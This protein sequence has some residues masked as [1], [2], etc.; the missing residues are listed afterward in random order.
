MAKPNCSVH[1]FHQT[2]ITASEACTPAGNAEQSLKAVLKEQHALEHDPDWG[3]LGHIRSNSSLID[4]ALSVAQPCWDYAQAQ[5]PLPA[6]TSDYRQWPGMI[7][8]VS[9]GSTES[10]LGSN[11]STRA[12]IP[13][14]LPGMLTQEVARE[15]GQSYFHGA[16]AVGACASGLLTL[17]EGA[18]LVEMG[19]CPWSIVGVADRSLQDLMLGGFRSL[20]VCCGDQLPNSMKG[21]GIGFAPSE[22]AGAFT[23]SSTPSAH[24]WQL[25]SAIALGDASHET[26]CDDV[27]A[28][29]H[30]LAQLW[31]DCPEPAVIICHGTGTKAGDA[32]EN[33]ALNNGPWSETRRIIMKDSLGHSLGA[34][35]A[36]ELAIALHGKWS[37][38][39]KISLGFGG[40]FA[41]VALNRI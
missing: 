18:R 37:R 17:I 9:K 29:I 34:N 11:T 13:R 1:R 20:G 27:D 35:G 7:L 5:R 21:K 4:L 22:G 2:Y 39:W 32:I 26:R 6:E 41:G 36:S 8:T 15:L 24:S 19:Q 10:W 12:F 23:L 33:Q 16:P 30:L 31:T 3:W 28:L 14:G 40:H 25:I 38:I